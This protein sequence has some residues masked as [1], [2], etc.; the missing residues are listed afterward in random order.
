MA[1]WNLTIDNRA[2]AST[3][4]YIMEDDGSGLITTPEDLFYPGCFSGATYNSS[5]VRQYYQSLAIGGSSFP[6]VCLEVAA[7]GSGTLIVSEGTKALKLWTY[8]RG[9]WT[10]KEDITKGIDRDATIIVPTLEELRR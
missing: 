9:I 7:R 2:N 10:A 4:V 5:L 6:P 8:A 3:T 1:T